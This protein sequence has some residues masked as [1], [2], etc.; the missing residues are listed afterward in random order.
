MIIDK[1]RALSMRK[2]NEMMLELKI[3]LVYPLD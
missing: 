2:I 1:G 3:R